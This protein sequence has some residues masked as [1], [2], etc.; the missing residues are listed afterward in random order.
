[1]GRSVASPAGPASI[2]A[3]FYCVL[4]C[5]AVSG[6]SVVY[7]VSTLGTVV[8]QVGGGRLVGILVEMVVHIPSMFNAQ[9]LDPG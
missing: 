4:R 1:M 5:R 9:Y 8:I 6:G 3:L 7:L 2:Q